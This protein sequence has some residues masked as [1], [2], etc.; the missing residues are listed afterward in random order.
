MQIVIPGLIRNPVFF[1]VLAFARMTLFVMNS[2]AVHK[3][4][5]GLIT[6]DNC[7]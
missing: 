5:W 6:T 1:W 4:R 2:V 7:W 3:L